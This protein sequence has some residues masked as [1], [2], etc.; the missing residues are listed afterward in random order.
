[1]TNESTITTPSGQGGLQRFNEEYPSKFQIKPEWIIAGIVFVIAV[2][3]A[4]K[5][6]VPIALPTS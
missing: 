3:F 5:R 2:M 1:M 4:L 6:F